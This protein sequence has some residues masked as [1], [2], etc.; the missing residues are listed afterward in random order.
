MSEI[1]RVNAKPGD[2]EP[3]NQP[4]TPASSID[5]EK[6]HI[7]PP[8]MLAADGK[9]ILFRYRMTGVTYA[10]SRTEAQINVDC[11]EMYLDAA[12]LELPPGSSYPSDEQY[13]PEARRFARVVD[14]ELPDMPDGE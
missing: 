14:V 2:R 12:R 13:I 7:A 6:P 5:Y 11:C 3:W 9:T 1:P 10:R 4:R 8:T